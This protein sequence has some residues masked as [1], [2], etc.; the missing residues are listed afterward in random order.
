MQHEKAFLSRLFSVL[1]LVGLLS[2]GMMVLVVPD[3]SAADLYPMLES[4]QQNKNWQQESKQNFPPPLANQLYQDLS[5]RTGI[6]AEK[7]SVVDASHKTWPDGCLGL[8]NPDELCTQALVEGWRV[9][10]TNGNQRW[11]YRTDEQVRIY[12]LEPQENP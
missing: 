1:A 6:P 3:M 10:L 8:G 2:V 7:L 12:R 5:R 9:V 4:I 11:V